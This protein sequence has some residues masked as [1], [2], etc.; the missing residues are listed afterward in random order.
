MTKLSVEELERI[1]RCSV[2]VCESADRLVN[3]NRITQMEWA[4]VIHEQYSNY[5]K[6]LDEF[7]EEK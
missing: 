3:D 1:R 5:M 2:K 7:M 6:N 4:R